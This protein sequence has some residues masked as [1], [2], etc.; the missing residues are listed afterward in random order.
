[1]KNQESI[2]NIEYRKNPHKWN[3]E[4]INLSKLMKNKKVLE[5]GVGNGKTL[6]AILKQNPKSVVAM[7]FSSESLN[8]CRKIFRGKNISFV[9]ADITNLPFENEEFDMV[10]CYYVLNNLLKKER[11]KA[12]NEIIRVIKTKGK[13]LFEDFAVGDFRETN[14][15]KKIIESH[16][17]KNKNGIICHFFEIKEIKKLF[18]IFSTK[19]LV[20]R[21]FNPIITMPKL[22]R[23]IISGIFVK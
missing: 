13:L 1:M 17:I 3:K 14:K 2:W 20:Q 16:T 21:T 4:T 19:K 18:N 11:K 23:K 5:I 12:V 10:V 15:D 6:H 22:K 7:D 9:K 8:I